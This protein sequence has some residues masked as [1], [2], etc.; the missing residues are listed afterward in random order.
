MVTIPADGE[1]PCTTRGALLPIASIVAAILPPSIGLAALILGP[2]VGVTAAS[3][4]WQVASY[5]FRVGCAAFG[6]AAVMTA[7][8]GLR[9]SGTSR[10][11]ILFWIALGLGLGETLPIWWI[12]IRLLCGVLVV[13]VGGFHGQGL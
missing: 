3:P 4:L 12:V 10:Y 11:T 13:L 7:V 1:R 8:A 9:R 5:V 6:S 2:A